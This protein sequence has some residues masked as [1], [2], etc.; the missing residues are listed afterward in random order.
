MR[1][2]YKGN[3][4]IEVTLTRKFDLQQLV[5]DTFII[6]ELNFTQEIKKLKIL[7]NHYY[8]GCPGTYTILEDS[9]LILGIKPPYHLEELDGLE[10]K[11]PELIQQ[12]PNHNIKIKIK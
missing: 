5:N 6:K 4:K 9:T 12:I 10:I 3:Y 1:S 11:I 8:Q 7:I 2:E